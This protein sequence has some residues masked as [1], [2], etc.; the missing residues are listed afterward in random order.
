M[1]RMVTFLMSVYTMSQTPNTAIAV[2]G[3]DIGKNSFHVVGHDA[4]GAIVLRQKWPRGQVEARLANLPRCL[5]GI[6]GQICP[7][8]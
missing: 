4:R 8:L 2:I 1:G 3:I 6:G 5:I 7:T